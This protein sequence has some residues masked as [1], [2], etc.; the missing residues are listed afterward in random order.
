MKP[1]KIKLADLKRPEKNVRLHTKKQLEEF[2]RSVEM[3]GQI[4]PIVVDENHVILAGNGLYETLVNMGAEEADC[5]VMTGL[6]ENQKKKLMLA[7]NKV[8]SLGVENIDTVES[9][10]QELSDDL[11]IPG[12]DEDILKQMVSDA[13]EVTEKVAEYGTLNTDQI[14]QIRSH[15]SE[16]LEP[17]PEGKAGSSYEEPVYPEE[18]PDRATAET[19]Q[20]DEE[21]AEVRKF[22]ICPK[23]GEKIWL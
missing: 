16:K 21:P 22:V 12:Y 23:C 17:V 5:Y 1:V 15:D 7:D 19:T 3:F 6:S 11:D 13:E 20:E 9:F 10:I 2:Q 14:E 4:R 18:T 8:F